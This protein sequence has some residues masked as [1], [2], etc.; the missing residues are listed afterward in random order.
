MSD[1]YEYFDNQV[2]VLENQLELWEQVWNEDVSV[3]N[4]SLEEKEKC[5]RKVIVLNAILCPSNMSCSLS[6]LYGS[7][8]C[9][10]I[11]VRSVFMNILAKSYLTLLKTAL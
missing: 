3:G 7:P 8:F 6:N 1:R 9:E 4:Y 2:K 11:G 5:L 10:N